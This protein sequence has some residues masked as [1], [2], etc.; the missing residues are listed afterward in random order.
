MNILFSSAGRR[1]EL[2]KCFQS[3]AQD[4]GLPIKITA[5]DLGKESSA[6]CQIADYAYAVPPCTDPE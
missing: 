6:A 2:I 3:D 1:V 4:L 5:V